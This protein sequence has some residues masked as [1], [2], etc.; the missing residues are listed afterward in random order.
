MLYISDGSALDP[1]KLPTVIG[2]DADFRFWEGRDDFSVS[3]KSV[4]KI[5]FSVSLDVEP[6]VFWLL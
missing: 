6:L 1:S 5:T 3:N 2:C 4:A